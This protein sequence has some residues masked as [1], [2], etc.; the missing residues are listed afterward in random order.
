MLVILFFMIQKKTLKTLKPSIPKLLAFL[1]LGI[2]LLYF[3]NESIC[4]VF[5]FFS[6]C[7]KAYGFPFSYILNGNIEVAFGQ[8]K[9]AFLGSFFIKSG[10]FLFNPA[11]LMLD[12]AL[13]YLFS[14]IAAALFSYAFEKITFFRKK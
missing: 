7:Y 1:L 10:N 6:F 11:A 3:A 13:I 14:C 4:G 12:L 9:T 5:L 2:A 8:A